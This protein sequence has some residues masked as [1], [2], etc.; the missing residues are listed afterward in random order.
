MFYGHIFANFEW[1]RMQWPHPQGTKSASPPPAPPLHP[2]LTFRNPAVKMQN[3]YH[4][5]INQLEKFIHH[6]NVC[7]LLSKRIF[8]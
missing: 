8:L 6:K 1:A 5:I 4:K 3:K 7:K 2:K